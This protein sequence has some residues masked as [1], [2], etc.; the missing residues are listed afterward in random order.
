MSYGLYRQLLGPV[1][2]IIAGKPRF[3]LVVN[4]ALTSL[5]LQVLVMRDPV[6]KALKDVDWLIRSHAVTVLPS[7]GASK[8]CGASPRWRQRQTR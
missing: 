6:G 5:P 1:E 7:V 2:P 4:G 8:R 3:S